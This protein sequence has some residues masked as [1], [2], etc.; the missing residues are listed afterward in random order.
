[1]KPYKEVTYTLRVYL[2]DHQV[3]FGTVTNTHDCDMLVTEAD[4]W[5]GPNNW[6]RLELEAKEPA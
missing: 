6:N 1:M 3:S 2:D 5:A 4:R